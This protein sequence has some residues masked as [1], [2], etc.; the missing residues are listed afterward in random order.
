MHGLKWS[1]QALERIESVVSVLNIPLIDEESLSLISCR[2]LLGTDLLEIDRLKFQMRQLENIDVAAE[3]KNAEKIVDR[4][5]EADLRFLSFIEDEVLPGHFSY[6]FAYENQDK[7][8]LDSDS[9]EL[10]VS[11][12]ANNIPSVVLLT[13]R[14]SSLIDD[15]SISDDP[16]EI[17]GWKDT[18]L[19]KIKAARLNQS[20]KY[21]KWFKEVFDGGILKTKDPKVLQTRFIGSHATLDVLSN[22]LFPW[23]EY[24]EQ[25]IV[26][27]NEEEVQA[28][29]FFRAYQCYAVTKQYF[30]FCPSIEEYF[31]AAKSMYTDKKFLR[32]NKIE[33]R[34][35]HYQYAMNAAFY[36][37]IERFGQ[38]F[39]DDDDDAA[40][41]RTD[42]QPAPPKKKRRYQLSSVEAAA[43]RLRKESGQPEEEA[44]WI[45]KATEDE[46]YAENMKVAAFYEAYKAARK[47]KPEPTTPEDSPPP[48][49]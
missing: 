16:L 46:R 43:I 45:R 12:M 19:K 22:R 33:I 25:N 31:T 1:I 35:E 41:D 34:M 4:L 40:D 47:L 32:K 20:K 15:P 30:S 21:D 14:V 8:P 44:K 42:K 38:E 18:A 27:L 6:R 17:M 28:Y 29:N 23:D 7:I 3:L 26:G 37:G 5:R 48:G 13:E 10:T 49:T 36:T 11:R 39:A 9:S 24:D 2:N